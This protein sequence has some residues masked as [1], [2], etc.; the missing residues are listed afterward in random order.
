VPDAFSNPRH[1]QFALKVTLAGMIGYFFY[2]ASDY[3]GIHTVYYTPLIIALAS[4]GATMHKGLLRMIGCLIGVALGLICSIWVIPLYETL[5]MY[6]FIV[7]CLHALAAWIAVGSDRTSYI[8]LQIALTFDLGVLRDYG[9]PSS[10]DPLRDR[11]I[12]VILGIVIIS[13]VFSLVWP[14]SAQSIARDKLAGCLRA[15]ARL[16]RVETSA[17]SNAQR[18]QL[19][20]EIGTR[21]AE[22]NSYREQAGFEALLYGPEEPKRVS[23]KATTAA[24]EEVYVASLPWLRELDL[25]GAAEVTESLAREVEDVA[26]SIDQRGTAAGGEFAVAVDGGSESLKELVRAVRELRV[27]V[28]PLR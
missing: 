21:L 11:F 16:L 17:D 6:L 19:E 26:N 1:V 10:I 9:P 22:A 27:V 4:T 13:V 3:F 25:G 2:T 5:G 18:Q 23:L 8:G 14:E 24:A 12:G 7:F 15:I 20:L 28:P